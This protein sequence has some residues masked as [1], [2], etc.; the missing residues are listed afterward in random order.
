MPW[1]AAAKSGKSLQAKSR[2]L[3]KQNLLASA[4][5]VCKPNHEIG[6]GC[7]GRE[8]LPSRN[9]CQ[10]RGKF[11]SQILKQEAAALVHSDRHKLYV[12]HKLYLQ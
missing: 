3:T 8:K 5:K 6:G 2:Q 7:Q 1:R 12:I 4:G 10:A 9:C 11:V